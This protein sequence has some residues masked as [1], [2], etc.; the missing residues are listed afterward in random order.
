MITAFEETSS[1][2]IHDL[3]IQSAVSQLVR[4]SFWGNFYL[5]TTPLVYPSGSMVGVRITPDKAGY[6]VSD[7]AMG[8]R[9]AESAEAQRSFGAHAGRLK[10]HLGIEYS[11]GHE[12][13]LHVQEKQIASAIRR[14]AYASHRIMMKV[15]DSTPAWDEQEI[16]ASLFQRLRD[17]FGDTKVKGDVTV[18]GASNIDWH[19]TAEVQNTHK[20]TFFDVVTPHHSSVFSAVSKFSDIRRLGGGVQPVAVVSDLN[21]MGKWLPLIAQEAE[22]IQ[23]DASEDTIRNLVAEAA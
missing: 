10:E 3:H 9:E 12:V 8:Y 23:D 13:R 21:G 6:I 16:G 19:F 22:V 15:Y 2:S 11:D 20:R 1:S 7:F 5:V 17:M 4:V 18:L 14:V